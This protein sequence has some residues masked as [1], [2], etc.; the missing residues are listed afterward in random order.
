MS[1][2]KRILTEKKIDKFSQVS[3]MQPAGDNSIV[4]VSEKSPALGPPPAGT[5][6]MTIGHEKDKFCDG[7][8]P[9]RPLWQR[10]PP[11]W[12]FIVSFSLAILQ[13]TFVYFLFFCPETRPS[14]GSP[15]SSIAQGSANNSVLEVFQVQTPVHL[16]ASETDGPAANCSVLLMEHSFGF[17]YGKPFVGK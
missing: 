9:R 2:V 15:S 3:S 7:Q 12:L 1:S 8:R 14:Y 4:I 11:F 16:R 13:F 10:M 17:S 5:A 6:G